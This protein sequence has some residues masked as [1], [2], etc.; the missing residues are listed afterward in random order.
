MIGLIKRQIWRSFE[1]RKYSHDETITILAEA[2]QVVNSRPL[3]R[4]LWPQEEQPRV[5]LLQEEQPK[6]GLPQREQHVLHRPQ[7]EQPRSELLQELQPSHGGAARGKAA[8]GGAAQ[9]KAAP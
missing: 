4:N 5:K 9:D 8:H 1:G 7:R 3:S 2:T 6:L